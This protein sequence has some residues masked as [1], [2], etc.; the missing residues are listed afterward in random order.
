MSSS[1]QRA[2]TML[3]AQSGASIATAATPMAWWHPSLPSPPY[4]SNSG[5]CHWKYYLTDIFQEP[6]ENGLHAF[7]NYSAARITCSLIAT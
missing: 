4:S 3:L 2:S 5:I 1:L 6:S 7:L